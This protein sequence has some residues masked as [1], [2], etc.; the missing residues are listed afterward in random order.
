MGY[1][2][3]NS[4]NSLYNS[5]IV[6]S[7]VFDPQPPNGGLRKFLMF[8]EDQMKYWRICLKASVGLTDWGSK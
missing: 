7:C 3:H 6:G 2:L 4:V 5:H 8:D 1:I